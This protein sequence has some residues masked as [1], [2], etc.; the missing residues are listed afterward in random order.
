M[1]D[2]QTNLNRV[3]KKAGYVTSDMEPSPGGDHHDDMVA[4]RR[5]RAAM[6]SL[7]GYPRSRRQKRNAGSGRVGK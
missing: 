3:L 2:K 5:I 4:I 1:P 7:S 6:I